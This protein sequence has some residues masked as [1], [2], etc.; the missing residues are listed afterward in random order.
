MLSKKITKENKHCNKISL[1]TT[2]TKI[3]ID[4]SKHQLINKNLKFRIK[5]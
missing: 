2:Q 1:N 4:K 5:K 3:V